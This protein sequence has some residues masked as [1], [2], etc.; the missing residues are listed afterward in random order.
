[1]K[2]N[3]LSEPVFSSQDLIKEIYKGNI[4]KISLSKIDKNDIEY[5]S[6]I[7]FVDNNNLSNWPIPQPYFENNQLQENFDLTN[8]SNW[9]IPEEYK[10]FNIT[11]YLISLCVNDIELKRVKEELELFKTY[12]MI[13][14]LK[15]LKYLVDKMREDK[16][17]W[18]VGRGS[19]VASYCLYLLGVH[20]IDSIKYELDI[21]EFLR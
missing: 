11:E 20:K 9:Y 19:S 3:Q 10:D 8:Q 12:N 17:L 5:M 1:M 15:F 16:I 4:S 13:D 18:G 6:Y 14:L 21:R 2:L 7:E